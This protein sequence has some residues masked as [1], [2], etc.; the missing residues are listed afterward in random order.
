MNRWNEVNKIVCASDNVCSLLDDH[1]YYKITISR[2]Q[3]NSV[4]VSRH[5]E[6][7]FADAL[8]FGL[9]TRSDHDSILTA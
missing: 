7:A 2:K 8:C 1:L 5:P 3:V 9:V 6:S 4:T